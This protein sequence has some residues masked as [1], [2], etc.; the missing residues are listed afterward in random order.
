MLL[1]LRPGPQT[2]QM[3]AQQQQAYQPHQYQP[4]Q[5]Q[6]HHQQQ[7]QQAW[8]GGYPPQG[9]AGMMVGMQPQVMAQPHMGYAPQY[10]PP[11]WQQQHPQHPQ[12]PQQQ[13]MMMMGGGMP[14]Q[15]G[16]H[17][18]P[19][20][21]IPVHM[22]PQP[23]PPMH[24]PQQQP[25]SRGASGGRMAAPDVFQRNGRA[26]HAASSTPVFPEKHEPAFDFIGDALRVKK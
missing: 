5:Y 15:M 18:Q 14:P 4:H 7:Q 11:G 22:Q 9:G 13:Q 23:Q 3:P 16:F 10:P 26:Q 17:Q 12:H 20:M 21:Q 25:M 6:P 8:Q 2:P 19:R 1:F 24:Q